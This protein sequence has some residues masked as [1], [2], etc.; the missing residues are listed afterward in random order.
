[1]FRNEKKNDGTCAKENGYS[2]VS[3][4]LSSEFSSANP[5]LPPFPPFPLVVEPRLAQ[6]SSSSIS[7]I[8]AWMHAR[9]P[10]NWAPATSGRFEKSRKNDVSQRAPFFRSP[11]PVCKREFTVSRWIT[12]VMTLNTSPIRMALLYGRM[13]I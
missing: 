1:M 2:H 12:N 3:F 5:F 4:Y 13:W 10:F 6:K 7:I 9:V 11:L 8:S